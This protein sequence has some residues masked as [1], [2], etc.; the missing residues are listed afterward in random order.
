MRDAP[1]RA[2]AEVIREAQFVRRQAAV[3]RAEARYSRARARL[4]CETA[5]ILRYLAS[6]AFR[7]ETGPE[8]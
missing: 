7:P 6:R 1:A 4:A 3:R 5:H 8:R 2:R